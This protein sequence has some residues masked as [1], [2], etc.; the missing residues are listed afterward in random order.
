MPGTI[1]IAL[2]KT[3]TTWA[4]WLVP[5]TADFYV[6]VDAAG[7]NTL[8]QARKDLA[9]IGLDR[10][11]GYF[12]WDD[13]AAA[14]KVMETTTQIDAEE[15]AARLDAREVHVLDVRSDAEWREG[16]IDGAQ[17]IPLGELRDRMAEV[18]RDRTVIVHCL[19]GA[20]SAIATSLLQADGLPHTINFAGG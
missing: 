1:N 11:A 8:E 13:L 5:Y 16:H 9:M 2:N 18:P 4:G 20:R 17:H 10:L 6:I 3:F 15:L 19:G 12:F 7:A 14:R